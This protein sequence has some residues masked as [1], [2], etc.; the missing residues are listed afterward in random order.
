VGRVG[1]EPTTPAMS[2]LAQSS[3]ATD[4]FWRGFQSFLK[5]T[6]NHRST[7]DRLNYA[8]RY[9]HILRQADGS[10]LLELSHEKRIHAMKSLAALAK[11]MGCYDRWQQPTQ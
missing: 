9:I 7:Q 3:N 2:R 5:Q 1:F 6:N 10:E 4:D 11:Y 8:C